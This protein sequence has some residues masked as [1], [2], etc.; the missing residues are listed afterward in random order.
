MNLTKNEKTALIM[1]AAAG[2]EMLVQPGK[3]DPAV[4]AFRPT[5]LR[6][7]ADLLE[8]RVT[9]PTEAGLRALMNTVMTKVAAVE[10]SP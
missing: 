5:L 3:D 4:L 10:V 2:F 9:D 7:Q 8:M 1:L 6:T